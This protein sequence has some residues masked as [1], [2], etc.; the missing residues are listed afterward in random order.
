MAEFIKTLG[1]TLG[2][3][4]NR[5]CKI[6]YSYMTVTALLK[7]NMVVFKFKTQFLHHLEMLVSRGYRYW[8]S[9]KIFTNEAHKVIALQTKFATQCSTD[10]TE[11]QRYRRRKKG[12]ANSQLRAWYDEKNKQLLWILLA[13]DGIHVYAEQLQD[14]QK[15]EKP[16]HS[17]RL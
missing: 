15:K 6:V 2:I 8:F 11:N 10:A 5:H 12:L 13:T 3:S 9:G 4:F 14:S 17:H 1:K 16:Y 7:I